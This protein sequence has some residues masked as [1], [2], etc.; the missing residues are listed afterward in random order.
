MVREN[1]FKYLGNHQLNFNTIPNGITSICGPNASR[2][3]KLIENF[4][5]LFLKLN[6]ISFLILCRN[7][8]KKPILPSKINFIKIFGKLNGLLLF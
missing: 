7:V 1:M 5:L 6:P 2:E 3:S 8:L 4:T